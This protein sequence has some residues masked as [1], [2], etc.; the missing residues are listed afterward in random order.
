MK[1]IYLFILGILLNATSISKQLKPV[2]MLIQ[3]RL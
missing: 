2:N 3:I 1:T